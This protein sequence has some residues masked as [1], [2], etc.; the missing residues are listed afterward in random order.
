MIVTTGRKYSSNILKGIKA[1][2]RRPAI[3]HEEAKLCF[4]EIA[5]YFGNDWT[6]NI[7]SEKGGNISV[8]AGTFATGLPDRSKEEEYEREARLEVEGIAGCNN[9]EWT[10][11]GGV[12]RHRCND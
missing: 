9:C 11:S 2:Y 8:K 5:K 7:K 10:Y 6:L 1:M 12:A 4:D 3:S